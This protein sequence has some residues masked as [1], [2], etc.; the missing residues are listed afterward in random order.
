MADPAWSAL[1]GCRPA[2]SFASALIGSINLITLLI[3]PFLSLIRQSP[4]FL[5]SLTAAL[6]AISFLLLG[7]GEFSL[8][9]TVDSDPR[10]GTTWL[11]AVGIGVAQIAAVVLSLSVVS[12]ARN[13][14]LSSSKAIISHAGEGDTAEEGQPVEGGSTELDVDKQEIAGALA[15]AYSFCGGM[16]LERRFLGPAELMPMFVLQ[17]A[18]SSLSRV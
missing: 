7:R 18:V 2:Y 16:C 14:L 9:G 12:A 3:A 1:Q 8:V 5:L 6:G 10:S 17:G 13:R 15:G 11:A 4:P